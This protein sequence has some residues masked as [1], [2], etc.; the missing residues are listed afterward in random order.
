MASLLAALQTASQALRV[1]PFLEL[2]VL[3][4]SLQQTFSLLRE[5]QIFVSWFLLFSFSLPFC[6]LVNY[7]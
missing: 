4:V 2:R 5:K 1:L 7:L 6:H 3:P